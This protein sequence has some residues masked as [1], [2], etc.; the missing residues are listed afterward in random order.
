MSNF[1]DSDGDRYKVDYRPIDTVMPSPENVII[2]SGSG[3]H[4]AKPY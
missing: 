1:C 3:K 4:V 2:A